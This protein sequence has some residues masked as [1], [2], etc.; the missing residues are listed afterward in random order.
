MFL[1]GNSNGGFIFLG[2]CKRWTFISSDLPN[3]RL[4]IFWIS[5]VLHFVSQWVG[6]EE[7]KLLHFSIWRLFDALTI[8]EYDMYQFMAVT[9]RYVTILKFIYRIL[10][11]IFL[12]NFYCWSFNFWYIEGWFAVFRLYFLFYVE[13]YIKKPKIENIYLS[14]HRHWHSVSTHTV[15]TQ[16]QYGPHSNLIFQEHYHSQRHSKSSIFVIF[17]INFLWIFKIFQSL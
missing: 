14:V 6:W 16:C 11:P 2:T 5:A 8:L 7:T 4:K 17:C 9:L 3:F 13:F 15:L 10:K 1:V 12:W